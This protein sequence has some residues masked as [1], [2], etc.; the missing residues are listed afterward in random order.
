M[1]LAT[2][3]PSGVYCD[4]LT[5][6]RTAGGAAYTGTSIVVSAAGATQV[7]LGANRAI[8]IDIATRT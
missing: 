2:G 7:T 3:L 5:A 6:G 4:L 1:S 8:A